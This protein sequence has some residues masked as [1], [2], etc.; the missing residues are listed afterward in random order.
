MYEILKH[1]H[2]GLRWIV[3][4]LLV[5]AIVTAWQNTSKKETYEPKEQRLALF[6]LIVS[7]LQLLLG[8]VLFFIS[9]MVQFTSETMGNAVMRF[10][11]VE[12]TTGMA[13]AIAL[14]TIGYSRAKRQAP[15]AKGFKTLATFYALGLLLI[16]ISIP[17]PFR[18]LGA[19]WF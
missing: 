17:W 4:I 10:F 2:S 13:L 6:T 1:A 5:V 3:L 16:L 8:L 15:S 7:H 11:T 18:G 14:I 19:G 12:H 9:P